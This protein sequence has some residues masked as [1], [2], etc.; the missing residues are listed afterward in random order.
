MRKPLAALGCGV[1][2][3]LAVAAASS[4]TGARLLR[5]LSVGSRRLGKGDRMPSSPFP[6]GFSENLPKF[7][8]ML[9]VLLAWNPDDA[10]EPLGGSKFDTL[11]RLD[12]GLAEDRERAFKLRDLEIPFKMFNLTNIVRPRARARRL[13]GAA[14]LGT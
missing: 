9:D 3:I 13:W 11:E 14:L 4:V 6:D 1:M 5:G 2:A 8:S 10:S 7:S 12:W